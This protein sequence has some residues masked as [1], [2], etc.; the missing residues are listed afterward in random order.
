MPTKRGSIQLFRFAGIDV[1]LHWSWFVLAIW[2]IQV[3][4][5]NYST[6]LWPALEYVALFAIVTMHE[7]G[8]ALACKQVGGRAD[9]IVLWPFGGVAYVSPPRRPGATLWCIAAGPLVNVGLLPILSGSVLLARRLGW[10]EFS[11]DAYQFI[12]GLWWMDLVLLI[13][14]MLPIFPLDGGQILQS[15]LWFAVGY[16]RSLMI[17]ASLGLVGVGALI[18]FAIQ[19]HAVWLGLMCGLVVLYCWSGLQQAR[20]LSRLAAAPKHQGLAC[21]ACHEA[22]PAG[23]FWMCG[24]CRQGFDVFSCGGVCPNCGAQAAAVPCRACGVPSPIQGYQTQI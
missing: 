9:Q 22:P 19:A 2:G 24:R 21:P 16:A 6:Y 5:E 8:H 18:L 4:K 12:V 1:Y 17:A 20:V 3:R 11:P 10:P 13:F 7:F 15:L 23:P 14:N